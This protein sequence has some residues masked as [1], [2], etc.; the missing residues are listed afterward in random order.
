MKAWR[1]AHPGKM[2]EYDKKWRQ[3][4]PNTAKLT[5]RKKQKKYYDSHPEYRAK[6]SKRHTIWLEKN[7]DR[8]YKHRSKAWR[9]RR[10]VKLGATIGSIDYDQLLIDSCGFCGICNTLLDDKLEFDHI[11][12]LSRGGSH[13]H[14]NLQPAHAYCNR[15]KLSMLPEEYA[16]VIHG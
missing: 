13:S 7:Y 12:P 8:A 15:R 11:I 3:T 1:L 4:N 9:K 5:D 6:A 2:A 14:D 16:Q 10:A